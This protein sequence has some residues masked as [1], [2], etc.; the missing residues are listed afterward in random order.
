MARG[1]AVESGGTLSDGGTIL[2]YAEGTFFGDC[3]PS[4][5]SASIELGRTRWYDSGETI[6]H[7]GDETRHVAIVLDGDVKL[8]KANS[9][10][11]QVVLELRGRG[12]L[13][14]ELSSIDGLPRSASVTTLERTEILS[15][16]H[17]TFRRLI[18]ERPTMGS[19]LNRVLTQR[20]RESAERQLE[21]S[22]IDSFG[23]V[24]LRLAELC[25]RSGVQLGD[26]W[27][28]SS[29]LSQQ[30][31]AEWLGISRDAVVRSLGMARRLGWIETGRR[32][33]IITDLDNLRRRG[34]SP[35]E[36]S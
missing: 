27:E 26:V 30:E 22:T 5:R 23:R 6:F 17:E 14:G 3:D 4:D 9:D 28:L 10:G 34:S 18:V 36:E 16:A 12:E 8:T 33:F 7:E 2:R 32:R 24:C 19:A 29:P 25:D 1:G 35:T 20:V 21:S 15:V 13:I 11:E 31:L